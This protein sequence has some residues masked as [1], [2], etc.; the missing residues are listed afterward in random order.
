MGRKQGKQG[1]K[2]KHTKVMVSFCIKPTILTF[3]ILKK[4]RLCLRLLCSTLRVV[5]VK[6]PVV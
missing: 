5:L 4:N 3:I 6:L 2:Q 1:E